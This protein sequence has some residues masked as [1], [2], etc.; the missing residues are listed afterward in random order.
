[1]CCLLNVSRD[2]RVVKVIINLEFLV[3]CQN[4]ENTV[5]ETRCIARN[6]ITIHEKIK[7]RI[8]YFDFFMT[9][10]LVLFSF[11]KINFSC[12]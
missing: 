5:N 3:E 2:Y 11:E 1:M 10:V 12:H 8:Y 9:G 4:L 7:F 6:G